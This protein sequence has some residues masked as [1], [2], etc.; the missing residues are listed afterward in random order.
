MLPL[1]NIGFTT[2]SIDGRPSSRWGHVTPR[3]W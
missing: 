2:T 1:F 3:K